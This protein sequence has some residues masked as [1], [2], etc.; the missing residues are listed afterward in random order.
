M[1][2][3][4]SRNLFAWKT[5]SN[6]SA[7]ALLLSALI[8]CGPKHEGETKADQVTDPQVNTP[9]PINCLT[10]EEKAEGWILLFDERTL[11]G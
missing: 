10:E 11:E 7:L 1:L 3:N 6:L 5:C 2:D 8:T 4:R 9:L